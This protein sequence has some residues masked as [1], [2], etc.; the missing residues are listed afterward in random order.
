MNADPTIPSKPKSK[1]KI[2]LLILGAL[3]V[4]GAGAYR[5]HVKHTVKGQAV[6]VEKA[7]VRTITEVVTATGKI[8]PAI[9]VKITPEVYG[10]ITELPFREGARVKKG[11]LIV[12]IK[13]DLYQ[14]GVDQQ[15]AAVASARSAAIHSK[16]TYDKAVLDFRRYEDLYRSHLASDSDYQTYKTTC[17]TSKADYAAALANV[18]QAEGLLSSAKDSLSKTVIYSPMDGT[19]SSRSCE[20]GERVVQTGQMAGTEIMRVADLSDMEMQVNVNENDIPHVK[21]GDQVVISVDAFPDKKFDGVVKELASSSENAGATAAGSAA[22]A[23]GTATDEVTNFLVR[24]RVSDPEAQL[25]PGMSATADIQTQ[26]VS[27]VIAVP[28]QSVTVRAAGGL[29]SDELQQ[30]K[31]KESQ[32]KSGND[33]AVKDE[34]AEARRDREELQRV[35]FVRS[36]DHVR[37]QKVETGI[38]DDTWIE[39]KTG[40]Q[41]GEEIVA[42]T[43]AAISRTLKDGMKVEVEAPKKQPEAAN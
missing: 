40:V 15:T 38:A 9:E 43:Y 2:G 3:I 19:V 16:A 18:D 31:A 11:E 1:L 20:V 27:H 17:D 8:Q 26:T 21:L 35:V 39:V 6:T 12:K 7:A 23:S 4:L 29:T 25:R 33:L 24:V 5:W 30:K 22:Q 32:E 42:G 10:E 13:P 28:I 37:M 41:P 34:R 36:G 14:A